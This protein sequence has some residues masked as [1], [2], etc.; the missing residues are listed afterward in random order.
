MPKK[1]D[2]LVNPRPTIVGAIYEI[3]I[4]PRKGK[5]Y[6]NKLWS[7]KRNGLQN[8]L[9]LSVSQKTERAVV[10]DGNHRLTLFLNKKVE[11]VPSYFFIEDDDNESFRF[12]PK[13]YDEASQSNPENIGFQIKKY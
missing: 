11:W 7:D 9:S 5:K 2:N 6:L 3:K 4:L 10:F 13:L 8:S 12:V 1:G